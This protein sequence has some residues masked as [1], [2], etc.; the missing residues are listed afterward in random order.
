MVHMICA[1]RRFMSPLQV[2]LFPWRLNVLAPPPPPPQKIEMQI[3]EI[4]K[5]Q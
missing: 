1:C 4:K 3:K 5:K 2:E